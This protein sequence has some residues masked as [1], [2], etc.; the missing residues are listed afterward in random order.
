LAD[1]PGEIQRLYIERHFGIFVADNQQ[2]RRNFIP[3]K[4]ARSDL[5]LIWLCG[6]SQ[7]QFDIH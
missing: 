4:L 5:I 6:A 1:N 3:F 7:V 2:N